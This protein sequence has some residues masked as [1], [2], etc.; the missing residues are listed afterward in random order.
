M[1]QITTRRSAATSLGMAGF[2]SAVSRTV[3]TQPATSHDHF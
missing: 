3:T 2:A 1:N